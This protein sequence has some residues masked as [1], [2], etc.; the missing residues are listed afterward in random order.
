MI[1]TLLVRMVILR[2]ATM[3]RNSSYWTWTWTKTTRTRKKH[4]KTKSIATHRTHVRKYRPRALCRCGIDRQPHVPWEKSMYETMIIEKDHVPKRWNIRHV[5][6]VGKQKEISPMLS[7]MK[8]ITS[9]LIRQYHI[10][11]DVFSPN[12]HLSVQYIK[13][14]TLSICNSL[15]PKSR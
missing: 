9:L 11:S 8:R 1:W 2:K 10:L 15:L 13:P 12:V 5:L 3:M 4:T 7:L 14:Y 6:F